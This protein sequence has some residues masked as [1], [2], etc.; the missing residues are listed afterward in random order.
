MIFQGIRTSIAKKHHIYMFFQ[1]G[2][3][4]DPLPPPPLDPRMQ[5]ATHYHNYN[6]E[7]LAQ[8]YIVRFDQ[9]TPQSQTAD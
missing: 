5:Q 8:T 2:G 1:G 7:D 3:G 6:R 4:L 9:Q